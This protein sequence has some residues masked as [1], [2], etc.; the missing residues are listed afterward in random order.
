MN[1]RSISMGSTWYVYIIQS[2]VTGKLYTGITN[3]PQKRIRAHNQ[4]KGAKATRAGRPWGLIYL[5][6]VAD[7]GSALRREFAIK[8]LPRSK[9]LTLTQG[10]TASQRLLIELLTPDAP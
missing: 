4:G 5:E 2:E 9:K 3:D 8:Q 10:Q 7:K 1:L 6:G